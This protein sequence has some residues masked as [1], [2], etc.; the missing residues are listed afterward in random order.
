LRIVRA[1]EIGTYLY[2]QRAWWYDRQGIEREN[3]GE[4]ASGS[5]LHDQHSRAAAVSGC[6]QTAAFVLLLGAILLL[7]AA[8]AS[9]MA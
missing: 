8:L 6:L 4:L 5:L 9:A 1:S 2:C 7:A 3:Q